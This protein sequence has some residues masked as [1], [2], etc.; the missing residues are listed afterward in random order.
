MRGRIRASVRSLIFLGLL[1]W[2]TSLALAQDLESALETVPEVWLDSL[3]PLNQGMN[4]WE[5][6]ELESTYPIVQPSTGVVRAQA[7]ADRVEL[8]VETL[9]PE[10]QRVKLNRAV[11]SSPVVVFSSLFGPTAVESHNPPGK[12]SGASLADL[13]S[14]PDL[15]V[16]LL[17]ITGGRFRIQERQRSGDGFDIEIVDVRLQGRYLDSN[18]SQ[19]NRQMSLVGSADVAGEGRG[20][21]SVQCFAV[22]QD[23]VADMRFGLGLDELDLKILLPFIADEIEFDLEK[24]KVSLLVNG[25]C[26]AGR[27]FHTDNH[28][29]LEE[30][31]IGTGTEGTLG[32][33]T[34]SAVAGMLGGTLSVEFAVD[35]DLLDPD[36]DVLEAYGEGALLAAVNQTADLLLNKIPADSR[37]ELK[38][39]LLDWI[40][41]DLLESQR[42][43][44]LEKGK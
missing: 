23:G 1:G 44:I 33:L 43:A 36:F 7:F 8:Y 41:P 38:G 39:K 18:P 31:R 29:I 12:G 24:G 11:F 6:L 9:D 3:A 35:G 30:V 4:L 32:E 16:E 17:D 2:P 10:H 15:E 34:L 14:Y 28:L 37:A 21:L 20:H 40:A 27:Y 22:P 25:T 42:E 5:N 26:K 19:G 13:L